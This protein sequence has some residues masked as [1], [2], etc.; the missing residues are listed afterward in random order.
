MVS[1]SDIER[2]LASGQQKRVDDQLEGYKAQVASLSTKIGQY[3]RM[4][5]QM[6]APP[7]TTVAAS[8]AGAP[9]V[10]QV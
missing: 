8:G 4:G 6:D 7:A 1:A 10:G 9:A 2:Q 3:Q 5:G